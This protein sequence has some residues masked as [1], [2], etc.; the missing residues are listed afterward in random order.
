MRYVA[1]LLALAL[2]SPILDCGAQDALSWQRAQRVDSIF[3]RYSGAPSPGAAVAVVRDG[4]LLFSKAYGLANIED[5]VPIARTTVFD[6]AS[7]SKQ[8]TGL[9]VAM[10]VE[11]GRIHLTDDIRKY[12]PEMHDFG[13][14]ITI[15]HLLHHTSGLRDWPST[16]H[17]AGWMFD[18]VISMDQILHMAYDQRTLNFPIGSEYTYS[19]TEYN[20]LAELI[21]RVTG[22]SF[23]AWTDENLFAPL[24]MTHT[25][26]R[27]DRGEIFPSNARAYSRSDDGTYKV[28]PDNLVALGSS[29]LFS[30]TDDLAKWMINFDETTVGGHSAIA[31]MEQRGV[32][33]DGTSIP[34]AFGVVNGTY[35][36]Q[37]TI[38]H[39]G[40]WA[41]FSTFAGRFPK[42][43]LGIIVLANT[44]SIDA[45]DAAHRIA[46][47]F[48]ERE[49]GP[50]PPG[51]KSIASKPD[52]DVA[53]ATLDSYAG[54]YRLG[55]GWF[56]RIRRDGAVLKTQATSEDEVLMS[57]KSPTEFWVSAYDAPMTFDRSHNGDTTY[58]TYRGQRHPKLAESRPFARDQ[59]A[60]VAGE[61]VSTEL[62]T[63]YWIE[64]RDSALVMTQQRY[65]AIPL[66]WLYGTEFGCSLG[67]VEFQRDG[68]GNV[69]SLT[70]TAGIRSR[71]NR[72]DKRRP[73]S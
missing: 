5:H 63:S 20:L 31:M 58:L 61:Y 40:G 66:S 37:Q 25:H 60:G 41:S 18:D 71:N 2:A 15:N 9:A 30:S 38:E 67:S 8:F 35:R 69:V 64:V 43:H 68:A 49:L 34:Y 6:L 57:S 73:T 22:K 7:V 50:A 36:G 47:I 3:A 1:P 45:T 19:N 55:P 33:N 28:T 26:F 32:L 24:G 10:L 51:A 11:Q 53:P 13:T 23:R 39:N 54:Q 65:G 16:L 27:D 62:H 56:V 70:I 4:A 42:Q 44:G 52:V 14:P 59:L 46:D 72:F 29:S 17:V 48:L 21:A 12:I